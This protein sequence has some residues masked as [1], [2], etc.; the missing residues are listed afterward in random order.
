[1]STF[2]CDL[3]V[4]NYAKWI[5]DT[6]KSRSLGELCVLTSPFLDRHNDYLQ[7]YVERIPEG[8]TLSDDGYT[9]RDLRIGGLEVDT[10]RRI[11]ILGGI[12]RSYG[13]T[14]V[15][16][17]LQVTATEHTFA[18]KKNDLLQAMLAV[19]SLI[20]VARPSILTLFKEDVA[21]YLDEK[22]VRTLSDIKL[23]G[24]SG[25]DHLF[26]FGIPKSPGKPERF[27]RAISNPD[28]ESI[29]L[30]MYAWQDVKN[31]RPVDSVAYAVLNDEDR[32]INPDYLSAL[33]KAKIQVFRWS[34]RDSR[35]P[36]LQG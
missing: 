27:I 28:R 23:T 11:E 6:T 4:D 1:M 19:D 14:Q 3:L 17:E 34:D 30:L 25:L 32:R 18:Q 22:G 15:G 31:V 21:R 24:E 16:D 5:R 35:I 26:D 9:L 29:V 2:D 10:E 7:I 20:N 36:T 33:D 12:L 13:V 8:W